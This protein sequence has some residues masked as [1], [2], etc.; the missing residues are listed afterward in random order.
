MGKVLLKTCGG[1]FLAAAGFYIMYL[2][3]K[4]LDTGSNP[5]LLL[6]SIALVSVGIFFLLRAAKSNDTVIAKPQA[7]NEV[8]ASTA[9]K[10]GFADM[11]KR[12]NELTS[13]W[14]KTSALRDKLK[15]IQISTEEGNSNS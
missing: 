8:A 1:L 5:L 3:L 6:L 7:T 10:R 2:Y 14:S 9:P 12:N 15:V 4:S 11:L 13:Q